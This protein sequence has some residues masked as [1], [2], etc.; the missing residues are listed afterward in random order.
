MSYAFYYSRVSRRKSPLNP[1]ALSRYYQLVKQGGCRAGG[2]YRDALDM[3]STHWCE[4]RAGKKLFERLERGDVL[5]IDNAA[6][7]FVDR[8]ELVRQLKGW[9]DAGVIVHIDSMGL[10]TDTQ[11]GRWILKGIF[12]VN[13]IRD[14]DKP[15]PTAKNRHCPQIRFGWRDLKRTIPN[16]EERAFAVKVVELKKFMTWEQM[17]ALMRE[18]GFVQPR[19]GTI[20]RWD[21]L[22]RVYTKALKMAEAGEIVLPEVTS[23][24]VPPPAPSSPMS[25]EPMPP[26][27]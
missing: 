15:K 3:A 25:F 12:T 7:T 18:K 10:H 20:M 8:R 9:V 1:V 27:S 23:S 4:R 5:V 22:A 19:T 6:T 14:F 11:E 26:P 13:A 24:T 16:E 21:Y 2:R 17:E